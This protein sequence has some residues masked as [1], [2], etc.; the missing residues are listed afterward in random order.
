M[1]AKAGALMIYSVHDGL[2]VPRFFEDE[3]DAVCE[4][5]RRS[6]DPANRFIGWVGM[7]QNERLLAYNGWESGD[8][9]RLCLRQIAAM[10][11]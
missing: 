2:S 9:L 6:A 8:V 5:E 7:L 1:E 10:N 11:Q 4:Y 3:A